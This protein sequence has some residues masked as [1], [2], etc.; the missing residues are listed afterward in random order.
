MPGDGGAVGAE[1]LGATTSSRAIAR[2]VGGRPSARRQHY[3]CFVWSYRGHLAGWFGWSERPEAARRRRGSSSSTTRAGDSRRPGR[4][5]EF[6]TDR[7]SD[8]GFAFNTRIW[9]VPDWSLVSAFA[10]LP[11]IAA[12]RQ[13]RA[14]RRRRRR[15]PRPLPRLRVRPPRDAGAVPGMWETRWQGEGITGRGGGRGDGA[16]RG[17]TSANSEKA[18]ESSPAEFVPRVPHRPYHRRGPHNT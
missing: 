14:V 7:Q 13:I 11:S 6:S 10:V 12:F 15:P 8:E 18:V 4:I 17:R 3:Q 9:A 1:L 16:V 5:S 2:S